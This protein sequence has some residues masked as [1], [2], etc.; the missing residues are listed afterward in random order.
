M[1]LSIFVCSLLLILFLCFSVQGYY[2]II[3]D[4]KFMVDDT[5]Y[6]FNHTLNVTSVGKVGSWFV[7]DTLKMKAMMGN[8]SGLV[9]C[10][11]A[12]NESFVDFCFHANK[13][14]QV[15]FNCSTVGFSKVYLGGNISVFVDIP[16]EVMGVSSVNYKNATEKALENI[17]TPFNTILTLLPIIIIMMTMVII[18]SVITRF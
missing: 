7:V 13:T 18:L 17:S 9:V 5:I 2:T 15:F 14:G 8:D 11:N 10:I 12:F 3:P 6:C 4:K 16:V 1:R